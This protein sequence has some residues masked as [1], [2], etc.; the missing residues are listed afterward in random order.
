MSVKPYK[1]LIRSLNPYINSKTGDLL[2]LGERRFG[3]EAWFKFENLLV[4]CLKE[5]GVESFLQLDHPLR[6][7]VDD[8]LPRIYCHKN[9][10]DLQSHQHGEFYYMQMHLRD[11]FTLDP[12]GWGVRSQY[13]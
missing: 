8:S 1:V 6:D 11:L 2:P 3:F 9:R 7:L 10:V 4:D 13:F 5:I 12:Q